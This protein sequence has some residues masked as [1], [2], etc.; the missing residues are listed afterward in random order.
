MVMEPSNPKPTPAAAGSRLIAPPRTRLRDH[1][2]ARLRARRLD[3]ELAAGTP[4]EATAALALRG[5]RLADLRRRRVLAQTLRR[6]VREAGHD[7]PP[8]WARITPR[9][10]RV[11][12]TAQALTTLADTL[13]RPGPVAPRGVAQA[14]LLVTDG[15]GPLYNRR[16][17]RSVEAQARSA[18]ENLRPRG[19]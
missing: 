12:A 11:T 13:A 8:G 5:Y 4:P 7:R 19:T 14:W 15:T 10:E 2:T 3:L 18:A 16:N 6:L 1:L 17:R 9:R